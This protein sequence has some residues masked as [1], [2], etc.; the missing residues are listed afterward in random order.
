MRTWFYACTNR[1][2]CGGTGIRVQKLLNMI[3][4]KNTYFWHLQCLIYIESKWLRWKCT[5]SA[6]KKVR[7]T[8][9]SGAKPERSVLELGWLPCF[10]FFSIFFC[11]CLFLSCFSSFACLF[12]SSQFLPAISLSLCTLSL[13]H[14]NYCIKCRT[15]W[16]A[17]SARR[18]GWRERVLVHMVFWIICT[19]YNGL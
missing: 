2:L 13:A 4:G 14:Q 8:S 19:D 5:W 11:L 7:A 18:R 3:W 16:R 10:S 6:W 15:N 9:H 17:C 1:S 12:L